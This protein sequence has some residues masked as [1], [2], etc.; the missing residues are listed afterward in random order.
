MNIRVGA[1]DPCGPSSCVFR[2]Y[3]SQSWPEDCTA[4][5]LNGAPRN[6]PGNPQENLSDLGVHIDIL[7]VHEAVS[8]HNRFCCKQKLSFEIYTLSKIVKNVYN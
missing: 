8:L 4:V 1:K 7:V 6:L 2:F 5:A 3:S